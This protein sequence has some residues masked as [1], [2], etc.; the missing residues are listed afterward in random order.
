[1]N[2]VRNTTVEPS[3]AKLLDPYST[4]RTIPGGWDVSSIQKIAKKTVKDQIAEPNVAKMLDPYST[5][6][7]IPGAWDVSAFSKPEHNSVE[8]Y[9]D[10]SYQSS[11]TDASTGKNESSKNTL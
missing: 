7:T 2:T 6:R 10:S 3:V 9:G 5:P 1:M 4:P 11:L 8:T